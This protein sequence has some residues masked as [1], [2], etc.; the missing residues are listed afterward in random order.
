MRTN[1]QI[2]DPQSGSLQPRLL[3]NGILIDGF[4]AGDATVNL[5]DGEILKQGTETQLP[6]T[7][8]RGHRR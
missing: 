3:L 1:R 6:P 8:A 4:S 2:R 5:D 7:D